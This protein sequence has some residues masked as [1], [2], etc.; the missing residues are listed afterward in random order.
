LAKGEGGRRA[1]GRRKKEYV[2]GVKRVPWD[3]FYVM[4]VTI[5]EY[6]PEY[7]DTCRTGVSPEIRSNPV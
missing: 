4:Y 7:I 3:A 6:D 1:R 2:V 5:G